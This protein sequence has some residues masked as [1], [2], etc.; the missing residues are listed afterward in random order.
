MV[1]FPP[2]WHRIYLNCSRCFEERTLLS[3][4]FLSIVILDPETK[5]FFDISKL[6]LLCKSE[7]VFVQFVETCYSET[8]G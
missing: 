2:S 8:E 5:T 3:R 6:F 7:I 1:L 4:Y